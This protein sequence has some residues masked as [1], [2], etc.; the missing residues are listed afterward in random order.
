MSKRRRG[1]IVSGVGWRG[2]RAALVL[3]AA[4][5]T[6]LKAQGVPQNLTLS[7]AIDVAEAHNPAFLSTKNDQ[8]AADWGVKEAWGQFLPQANVQGGASY[9]AAGV[10]R[11]GTVNLG[12][13][14]TDWY[15]SSY[16]L[17]ITWRLNG[18]TIFGLPNARASAQA[19]EAN[20]DA[21]R[22]QLA[23]QVAQRYVAALQAQDGVTVAQRDVD[24]ARQNLQLVETKV[25]SGAAAGIDAKQAQV[26]LGQAQVTLIQAQQQLGDSKVQLE[27]QLGATLPDSVTFS[28]RF[29]VFDPTWSADSLLSEALLSHPAVHAA[30]AREQASVA[31]SRQARASYFPTLVV[32]TGFY[33]YTQKALNSDYLVQQAKSSYESQQT[34]C[35]VFNQISAGLP[36]PLP[37]YPRDC[38][39]YDFTAQDRQQILAQN[40]AFPFD[41]TKQPLTLSVGVSIPLFSGFTRQRQVAAASAAVDDARQSLRQE[42]LALRTQL[43]QAYDALKGNYRIVQIQ[44]HNQEVAKEALEQQQRRYALGAVSILDLLQAQRTMATADQSYLRAVYDFHY[45]LIRLQAAVGR[46]LQP[47]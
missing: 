20:I 47:R 6:T 32:Q 42:K 21:Q 13:Q 30:E 4:T 8:S 22:F 44:K 43:T 11:Y 39:R 19:V 23:S 5:T 17:G 16:N 12:V 27:E 7:D 26:Q 37:T 10:Q 45:N 33:G 41:F 14:S 31:A 18:N 2:L 34:Q 25:S 1:R 35:E 38:S 9:Q 40:N 15:S 29:A 28:S 24:Y 3:L 46:P 36:Q